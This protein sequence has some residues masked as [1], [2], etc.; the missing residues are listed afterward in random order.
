MPEAK[1]DARKLCGMRDQKQSLHARFED[2][3]PS[4]LPNLFR[5]LVQTSAE[6]PKQVQDT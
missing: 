3:A 5:C 6:G 1:P 4:V 2:L